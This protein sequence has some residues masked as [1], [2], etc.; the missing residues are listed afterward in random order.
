[1]N[2]RPFVEG[3]IDSVRNLIANSPYVYLHTRPTYW[4]LARHLNKFILVAE[5][6]T[7]L[8][9]YCCVLAN[10]Q[11]PELAFMWQLAVLQAE[12]RRGVATALLQENLNKMRY[13]RIKRMQFAVESDNKV[14]FKMLERFS[15]SHSLD[16]REVD[17]YDTEHP[18]MGDQVRVSMYEISGIGLA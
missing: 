3:D 9:G 15:D 5:E 17:T 7:A 14:A 4:L 2:I 13:N 6:N 18:E 1:M 11:D 8:I 12:Q 10:T 16:M